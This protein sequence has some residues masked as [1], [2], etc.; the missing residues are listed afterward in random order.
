[1]HSDLG[2]KVVYRMIEDLKEHGTA[3]RDPIQDGKQIVVII[4]PK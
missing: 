2:M 4:N 3:E 1:M